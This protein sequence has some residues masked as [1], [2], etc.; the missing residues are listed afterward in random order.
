M[1]NIYL[2]LGDSLTTGYGVE[3]SQSFAFLFYRNL[4]VYDP[5]LKY[6]NLG[7]NGLTSH[8]LAALV[9]QERTFLLIKQAKIIS[10]TIGSNDLLAV[11][12]SLITGAGANI[13]LTLGD[14]NHN[15]LVIGSFIRRANPSALV[16]I[17]TIY[18][19]LPPMNKQSTV[20][21]EGLVKTSNRS[22]RKMAREYRFIVVP[23]AKAVSG[24]EQIL[25][26]PDH[27]HPNSLGHKLIADL[28]V[29]Y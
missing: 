15:L 28:L 16:K 19:P 21:A 17:A 6:V 5:G 23:V 10:I 4:A 26:G 25:L 20:L 27:I 18:N 24:Q 3:P 22:I 2:A 8:E 1:S 14:L 29:K 9:S 13:D 11:G 12:K 7:V